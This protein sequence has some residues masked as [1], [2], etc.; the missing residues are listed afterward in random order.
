MSWQAVGSVLGMGVVVGSLSAAVLGPDPVV[1]E[2][3]AEVTPSVSVVAEAG[4]VAGG[5][6]S[7]Q[8]QGGVVTQAATELLP[9]GKAALAANALTFGPAADGSSGYGFEPDPIG[10]KI[11]GHKLAADNVDARGLSF[12]AS[13]NTLHVLDASRRS[14][15]S[16]AYDAANESLGAPSEW[17]LPSLGGVSCTNA[18]GLARTCEGGQEVFY[19]LSWAG[20]V[21][22]KVP[23]AQQ[24]PALLSQGGDLVASK[25]ARLWRFEPA[26]GCT[27]YVDLSAGPYG[28]GAKEV[29]GLTAHEGQLYVS[30]DPTGYL[31]LQ[32]RVRRGVLRLDLAD[33]SL[34]QAGSELARIKHMPCSGRV[35]EEDDGVEVVSAS[36]GLCVV[37]VEGVPY[38]YGSV[39]EKD[40]YAADLASGRGLF[41]FGRP[42]TSGTREDQSVWGLTFGAGALWVATRVEGA[43]RVERVNVTSGL[44]TPELGERKIRALSMRVASTPESAFPI[45]RGVVRHNFCEPRRDRHQGFDATSLRVINEAGSNAEVLDVALSVA[46]DPDATQHLTRVRYTG[47]SEPYYA[48]RVEMNTWARDQRHFVYPHRVSK[49]DAPGDGYTSDDETLYELSDTHAYACFVQRVRDHIEAVYGVPADM[50]NPYWAARNVV[51]YMLETYHYPN[52]DLGYRNPSDPASGHF[53][54]NPASRKVALSAGPRDGDEIISCSPSSVLVAGV[55]RHLGI[56]ARWIGSTH[57]RSTGG[58]GEEHWDLDGDGFMGEDEEAEGANG[59]RWAEV[60]LGPHYGWQLFDGTPS[61]PTDANYAEAPDPK[62][63]WKFMGECAGPVEDHRLVLTTS[64]GKFLA[65]FVDY[66]P[67]AGIGGDQRYNLRGRYE[68]PELWKSSSHRVRFSNPCSLE[69]TAT[70]TYFGRTVEASWTLSGPWS[71]D[72]EAEFDLVLERYTARNGDLE[73][74]TTVE[75][76]IAYD[77]GS[78][79]ADL[80][81]EPAGWYRLKLVKRGDSATGGRSGWFQLRDLQAGRLDNPPSLQLDSGSQPSYPGQ[82][83]PPSLQLD[84]GQANK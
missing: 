79:A 78:F 13:S 24:S 62:A 45:D 48:A 40:L 17:S 55:M 43:D 35:V 10:T 33:W 58:K 49:A 22:T 84:S 26:T 23:L 3:R 67:A 69:L 2:H 1:M 70:G 57:Q 36:Y 73:E 68:H 76:R 31:S 44:D 18:R 64:S 20:A 50:E 53:E 28:I 21:T 46:S 30:F 60:W 27:S 65:T 7:S 37:H 59:H 16:Y 5:S 47:T 51:E 14:I 56:P 80:S 72:P 12:D 25:V 9:P 41:S 8:A 77:A 66:E 71:L 19:V 75:R 74:T 82:Q 54:N 34:L 32:K 61:E 6:A 83:D 39:G 4:P 15:F 42:S 81:G 29:L 63:Q 11:G 52:H 38:L